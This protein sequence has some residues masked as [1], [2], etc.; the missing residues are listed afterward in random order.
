MTNWYFQEL[1]RG[2]A[3]GRTQVMD[4][5][6]GEEK[7][8]DTIIVREIVQN[9]LDARLPD[10]TT[11]SLKFTKLRI[12]CNPMNIGNSFYKMKKICQP[13]IPHLKASGHDSEKW[14][15]SDL[16]ALII[17]ETGTS[18]LIGETGDS[19]FDGGDRSKQNWNR[20]WYG[21]ADE[22]KSGRSLGRRGQGKITYH[23]A[24]G[25]ST[26][27]ALTTQDQGKQDLLFG[28]AIFRK[29]HTVN[30]KE[31]T[32]HSFFC[33]TKK[34]SNDIQPEPIIDPRKIKDFRN[35]FDLQRSANLTGTSWV[36]PYVDCKK[37][38]T[39]NLIK[40]I[41]SEFYIAICQG[42]ISFQ[43][44]GEQIDN[45]NISAI[46]DKYQI[47]ENK[48]E[49]AHAKWVISSI[50]NGPIPLQPSKDWY[51]SS[52]ISAKECCLDSKTLE[53]ASKD[54]SNGKTLK[55]EVP[56]PVKLSC[57]K[58][59]NESIFLFL[60]YKDD[61]KSTY[62]Q[63]V[64][65]C[66]I[67]SEERYLTS[68]PGSFFGLMLATD[69]TIVDFLGSAEEASHLK[70]NRQK[71]SL[72]KSFKDYQ[73][74]L[75]MIRSSLP[76]FGLL[77]SDVAKEETDEIFDD[78]LSIPKPKGQK[79]KKKKNINKPKPPGKP[80][81]QQPFSIDQQSNTLTISSGPSFNSLS[82]PVQTTFVFAYD[83]L[84]EGNAFNEY[85]HFDFDFSKTS[86]MKLKTQGCK[87]IS[88][89]LNRLEIEVT[90]NTFQL[91]IVGFDDAKILIKEII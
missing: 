19:F 71:E 12:S 4:N 32:R 23:L 55:L 36:I 29:T 17:E 56:I 53:Q 69:A 78:I 42:A 16:G 48:S 57:G 80:K 18:G 13:V 3:A 66:L 79:P 83:T 65:D 73:T 8:I 21:E 14:C 27:F 22:S 25:V 84:G 38:S 15:G 45:A 28:K 67:I 85:S 33:S 76:S 46:L 74:T 52:M 63:Y 2:D 51:D 39:E 41:V 72:R 87:I 82:L 88:N 44:D 86:L 20:F 34:M 81:S 90:H 5:F 37:W 62:E 47:F 61:L 89:D 1:R 91:E 75:S 60:Q 31:F 6:L 24:S 64:R 49:T 40:S 68:I 50:L 70:W 54:F 11:N 58:E 59:I 9:V 43:L 26:V 10:P 35:T 7:N 77:F 30:S